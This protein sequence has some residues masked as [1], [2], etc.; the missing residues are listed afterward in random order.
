MLLT[1]QTVKMYGEHE[2][3]VQK[4]RFISYFERVTSEQEAQ[5]FINKIKKSKT[6]MRLTIVLLISLVNKITF[7][8]RMMMVNRAEQ[9]EYQCLMC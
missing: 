6:G 7:K 3:I 5:N 4:S 2:I 9:Q 1:Y 8:R